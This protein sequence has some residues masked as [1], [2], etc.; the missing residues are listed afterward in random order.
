MSR[1][2]KLG[3]LLT[4]LIFSLLT[5]YAVRVGG[6]QRTARVELGR[7]K[8]SELTQETRDRLGRLEGD[9]LATYYV[10][11]RSE[12]PSHL[13]R[14]E[15]GVTDVLEA[16]SRATDGA[17]RYQIVDPSERPDL[18]AYTAGQRVAPF[19]VRSVER[20]AY[21]ERTIW[22]TLTLAYGVHPP[23]VVSGLTTEH[24]PRLQ[25][26]ILG[27]LEQMRAPRRPVF[28]VAAADPARYT[29]LREELGIDGE[30]LLVDPAFERVPDEADL[31]FW[32]DPEPTDGQ[33]RALREYAAAG[34]SAVVMGSDRRTEL[35]GVDGVT[36]AVLE[37]GGD[38]LSRLLGAFGLKSRREPVFDLRCE[39]REI[40]D[41]TLVLP[42]QINCIAPNQDF[43]GLTGQPNGHLLFDTPMPIELD[44]DLAEELG[45]RPAILGTTSEYTWTQPL[46]RPVALEEL[47]GDD[48][49][50][51]PKLGLLAWLRPVDPW[52]GSILFGGASSPLLNGHFRRDGFAHRTFLRVLVQTLTSDE[53]LVMRRAD[54]EGE[55][56]LPALSAG[57]RTLWRVVTIVL[58]PLALGVFALSRGA[59]GRRSGR[60]SARSARAWAVPVLVG[61]VLVA[62]VPRVAPRSVRLDWSADDLNRLA[63]Q[64]R[65]LAEGAGSVAATLYVSEGSA[66]PP[67]MR[68]GV[69]RLRDV[70]RELDGGGAEIELATIDPTASEEGAERSTPFRIKSTDEDVT[71]VRSF[72]CTLHLEAPDSTGRPGRTGPPGRTTALAFPNPRA[73]ENLELRLAFAFWRLANGREPHIAFASDL[74][75][76][77]PAEAHEDYQLKGRFAPTGTDVYSLARDVLEGVDFRVT[78]VDP[79]TPAI[80]PDVDLLI[81]VQPRRD[82]GAM[83]EAAVGTLRSG[84]PTVLAAQHFNIQPRQYRGTGFDTVYWPQ[85]QSPDVERL[86]FPELGLHFTREVLFDEL[87]T[88][89]EVATHVNLDTDERA[90]DEQD[91]ALPFLLR[92]SAANFADS[93]FTRGLG[94]QAFIWGTAIETDAAQLAEHDLRAKSLITTSERSWTFDWKGGWLPPA[95]LEGPVDAEGAPAPDAFDP[96]LSLMTLVEGSF[97]PYFA[98]DPATG[99]VEVPAMLPDATPSRLLCI[100]NSEMF[101][102]H[103]LL[104]EDFRADHLLLNA[105]FELTLGEELSAVATRRQVARGFDFVEPAERL[106]WRGTVLLSAPT[107]FV[108]FGLVRGAR[109]K[110]QPALGGAD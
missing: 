84:L 59:L 19:R 102:N 42:F 80:P 104:D 3:V 32:L 41:R 49:E 95:S 72:H 101:K 88:T 51:L 70:L 1:G 97:P 79:R 5:V 38:E 60:T 85:P 52:R 92:A 87:S 45:W 53:R 108:L 14:L 39:R 40:G 76:L 33:I 100:G 75:R 13:R 64:T 90:Y 93:P 46:E 44:G 106:R 29:D 61:L 35:A 63:P 26:V 82:I 25:E 62:I 20:D 37:R 54:V 65:A 18:V 15:R 103:R 11:R 69:R 66:L 89:L 56:A 50:N 43:R 73:F 81:W 98:P 57:A 99:E 30:V 12:M 28:A 16:F 86:Y 7:V 71:T 110:R 4:L 107:L 17:F 91:S 2:D 6:H 23:A 58:V 55:E 96:E 34:G 27:H 78:H 24:L 109:R 31:F 9:V 22:S 8:L 68:A 83:L 47:T 10:S 77:S 21:S 105:A 36:T 67:D 74:P 94:D 48:Q